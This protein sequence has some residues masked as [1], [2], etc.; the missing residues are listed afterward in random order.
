MSPHFRLHPGEAWVAIRVFSGLAPAGFPASIAAAMKKTPFF[1]NGFSVLKFLL[2]AVAILVVAL[3][4]FLT[5]FLSPTAKWAANSQLPEILGTEASVETIKINLWSGDLELGGVRVADP[6]D[7]P[8][9]PD[10]FSLERLVIDFVPTSV[11][12]DTIHVREIRV[13]QPAVHASRSADGTFSFEQLK[14]FETT[15]AGEA[16]PAPEPAAEGP[17]KAIRIDSIS[18]EGLAGSFSEETADGTKNSFRL[19]D[20]KFLAEGISANPGKAVASLPPGVDLALVRLSDARFAYETTGGAPAEAE[21]QAEEP[22]AGTEPT[23]EPAGS[24]PA[25]TDPVRIGMFEIADFSFHYAD[26][27]SDGEPLDVRVG[28][29]FVRVRDMAFDPSNVLGRAERKPLEAE[30]GFQIAQP[31]EGVSPAEFSGVAKSGVI[32]AGIPVTAGQVQLTGFELA[33]IQ[34][35]VPTGVQSAIGGP[36]FDLTAR[37]FVSPD[38]LDGKAVIVSS[39][40]VRTNLSI[41]GTPQEP[42]I[43]GSEMLLNVVGRPGQF[44]GTIAGDALQGGVEVVSG[45]A[46]AAGKLAK[47]AGDT[48]MGFGKGLLNTGKGLLGGDLKAA[49]KGLEE[50]TVGTVKT[51]SSA[52]ADSTGAA[53]SGVRGAVDAGSGKSRGDLWRETSRER[54]ET[55]EEAAKQWLENDNFPPKPG[56]DDPRSEEE[57]KN[58][59]ISEERGDDDAGR[60]AE[61]A[62]DNAG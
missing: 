9:A 25:E 11:F 19:E 59:E 31:E 18:V 40:G 22:D 55:F 6:T 4:A 56:S 42:K 61:A 27:P 13:A 12:S 24:E 17:G 48:V 53:A 49:G 58:P 23:D 37:W 16:D 45:A 26:K 54:H 3:L 8:D 35:L 62:S 20:F 41:G 34:P 14:V 43:S 32:G 39:K 7:A 50:A 5:F 33:T 36:G 46:D 47:G 15:P 10:L 38:K 51:A 21:S 30:L 28:K 52:V 29:F 60:A 57:P 2:F 1:P 44:L